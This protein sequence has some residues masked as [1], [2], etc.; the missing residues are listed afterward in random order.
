[1]SEFE[2]AHEKS[3]EPSGNINWLKLGVRIT[4]L[5]VLG[6]LVVL[7]IMDYV[8]RN[9]AEK[10]AAAWQSKYREYKKKNKTLK[11]SVLEELIL[12]SPTESEGK[13]N[14]IT[15]K[16]KIYSWRL[17]FRKNLE[18]HV[19]VSKSTTPIVE[20][21]EWNFGDKWKWEKDDE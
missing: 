16:V 21:V 5:G 6:V 15:E 9:N 18:I 17:I 20:V 3:V 13:A 19:T 11:L 7:A 12:G 1:M 14:F 4:V 8:A 2:D 10:T